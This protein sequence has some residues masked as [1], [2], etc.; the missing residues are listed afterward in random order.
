[1][2]AHHGR[3]EYPS[4]MIHFICFSHRF[5]FRAGAAADIAKTECQITIIIIEYEQANGNHY[6][7]AA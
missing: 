2:D 5:L 6:A 1:M 4:M 7:E 3:N